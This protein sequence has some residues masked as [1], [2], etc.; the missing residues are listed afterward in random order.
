MQKWIQPPACLDHGLHLLKSQSFQIFK[1]KVKNIY[2]G[3]CPFQGISPMVPL[4]C[5]SNLVVDGKETTVCHE[6]YWNLWPTVCNHK[7]FRVFF[8]CSFIDY[9]VFSLI[10]DGLILES[11]TVGPMIISRITLPIVIMITHL[12][13]WSL[14]VLSSSH[15]LLVPWSYLGSHYPL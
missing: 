8:S 15:R 12:F 9:S 5:R 6:Y 11:Y 10:P 1:K 2:S 14:L 13:R 3:W 7:V 4:S